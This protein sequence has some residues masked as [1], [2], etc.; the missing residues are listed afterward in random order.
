MPTMDKYENFVSEIRPHVKKVGKKICNK[1]LNDEKPIST[2]DFYK[3]LENNNIQ[4]KIDSGKSRLTIIGGI[5]R[6][7]KDLFERKIKGRPFEI[8]K[9]DGKWGLLE[10]G[11]TTQDVPMDG[12]THGGGKQNPIGRHTGRNS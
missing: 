6:N 5:Y 3:I 4:I 10:K 2:D 11:I 8:C 9:E 12:Y 1:F 7:T